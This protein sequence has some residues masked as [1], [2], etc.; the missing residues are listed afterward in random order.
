M[1]NAGETN[2]TYN[3]D[4]A[5]VPIN[6]CSCDDCVKERMRAATCRCGHVG[7]ECFNDSYCEPVDEVQFPTTQHRLKKA[8]EEAEYWRVKYIEHCE[9]ATKEFD[10][11]KEAHKAAQWEAIQNAEGWR[12][13]FEQRS[14]E[15]TQV[16]IKLQNRITE[17]EGKTK[18]LHNAFADRSNAVFTLHEL[19]DDLQAD[20]AADATAWSS[21]DEA[22]ESVNDD[23]I[24]QQSDRIIE[25]ESTVKVL[26]GLINS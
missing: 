23:I 11:M 16:E 1:F 15:A 2:A 6:G 17:L 12:K 21:V 25:L 18:Q 20:Y 3:F 24:A 8:L 5:N 4:S 10:A 26:A 19:I 22:I 14:D 9:V 13:A 7:A